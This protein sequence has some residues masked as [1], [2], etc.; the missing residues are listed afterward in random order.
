M[1]RLQPVFRMLRIVVYCL[2][3]AMCL[4]LFAGVPI[5]MPRF[6]E[7]A[8]VEVVVHP[9]KENTDKPDTIAFQDIR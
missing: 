2:L 6:R 4:C 7:E 9:D 8:P 5:S 3:A 1:K